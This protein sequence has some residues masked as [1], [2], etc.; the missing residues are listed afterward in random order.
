MIEINLVPDVKQEYIRARLLRNFVVSVSIVIGVA[1]VGLAVVL[2]L[3]LGGQIVAENIQD[4]SISKESK[5][6]TDIK[7]LNKVVT[8]QQQLEVIDQQQSDKLINSRLFDAVLAVNPPAPNDIKLTGIKLDPS[9]Q[10][11]TLEGSAAN[12]FI[13]LET[14]KKTILKTY[15]QIGS[16]E[17]QI[18][19]ATN[20]TPGDTGFGENAEGQRVLRFSFTFSYPEELFAVSK[21]PVTIVTPTGRTDVTDSRLGVPQSLFEQ[22]SEEGDDG[23]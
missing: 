6:L 7:D 20:I 11:I 14:F 18:D 8:I 3:V 12:G 21:D 10:R 1:V 5:K 22:S 23:R 4:G 13:A 2:G 17:N 9:E 16:Q 15:I 19:L